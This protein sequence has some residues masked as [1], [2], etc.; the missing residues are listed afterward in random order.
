M[1]ELDRMAGSQGRNYCVD[2][3]P[4]EPPLF[5][6][7]WDDQPEQGCRTLFTIGL[8]SSSTPG[9]QTNVG[10]ELCL[11]VESQSDDWIF[12][13]AELARYFRGKA[14]FQQGDTFGLGDN[15]TEDTT[16]SAFFL[17]PPVLL[18]RD[19]SHFTHPQRC[20]QVLQIYPIYQGERRFVEEQGPDWLIATRNADLYNVARRD[21][22]SGA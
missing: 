21:E 5:V 7:F 20:I 11:V 13:L 16:M 9:W 6:A 15:L 12:A 22:S 4:T 2:V 8:S 10:P 19:A 3:P 18:G 14:R 1:L 17:G